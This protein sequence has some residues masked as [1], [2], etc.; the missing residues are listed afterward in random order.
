[1]AIVLFV[2]AATPVGFSDDERDWFFDLSSGP[3][4]PPKVALTASNSLHVTMSK[5]VGRAHCF[6]V[7][8]LTCLEL[9]MASLYVEGS[10]V[11]L[12]AFFF[13]KA[14]ISVLPIVKSDFGVFGCGRDKGLVFFGGAF[15]VG[16]IIPLYLGS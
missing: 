7:L 13:G 9:P 14:V 11:V 16:G 1:M 3:A 4:L 10:L 8:R 12:T 2:F 15:S 5:K 6:G